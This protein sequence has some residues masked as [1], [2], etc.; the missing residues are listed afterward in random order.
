MTEKEFVAYWGAGLSTILA[1]VKFWEI[2]KSRRRIE[3]G[4]SFNSIDV[5][6]NRIIIRNLSGTPFIITYWQL[7]FRERYHFLKTKP[8]KS[9]DAEDANS[10]ICVP[11]YS[12]KA[13]VFNNSRYFAWGNEALEGKQIDIELHIAGR[14][15]PLKF[16]VYKG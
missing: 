9:E 11:G 10:D 12:S 8:Y 1:I 2:W 3:I 7:H 5:V 13:I 4:Y 6:G 16:P 14:R 15:K